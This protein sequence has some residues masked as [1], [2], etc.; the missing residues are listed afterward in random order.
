L[1]AAAIE[2]EHQ[3]GVQPLAP[4]VPASELLELADQFGVAPRSQ[5][6]VDAHLKRR[7][8]LLF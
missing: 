8:L 4:G 3:L 5:V 2:S 1:A 7:V 6:G